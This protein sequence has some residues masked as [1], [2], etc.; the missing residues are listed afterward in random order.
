MNTYSS[1]F[2]IA[3][4]NSRSTQVMCY[5]HKGMGTGRILSDAIRDGFVK[6]KRDFATDI[7]FFLFGGMDN[8]ATARAILRCIFAHMRDEFDAKEHITIQCNNEKEERIFQ[9]CFWDESLTLVGK[10]KEREEYKCLIDN[11]TQKFW[12]ERWENIPRIENG[13]VGYEEDLGFCSSYTSWMAVFD[14]IK[15]TDYSSIDNLYCLCIVATQLSRTSHWTGY[16][17]PTEDVLLMYKALQDILRIYPY[18]FEFR[19]I[20][21]LHNRGYELLRLC[22]SLSPSGC[23]WRCIATTKDNTYEQCGAM[24][25]SQS[26]SETTVNVSNGQLFKDEDYMLNIQ[27]AA[28]RFCKEYPKLVKASKGSD[29][30][31]KKWF[32]HALHLVQQGQIFYCFGDMENC[33]TEGYLCGTRE[34][35][36]FPP[37]GVVKGIPMY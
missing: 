4:G 17:A 22:P 19:V 24:C 32:R 29:P 30:E 7:T 14:K 9:D 13:H 6:M 21:E 11:L 18:I 20:A 31:Y 12:E 5:L 3:M 15:P 26:W 37:A 27:T 8:H 28:D 33:I 35:L 16:C 2:E 36:E 10:Q 1:H 25:A 34:P 23:S